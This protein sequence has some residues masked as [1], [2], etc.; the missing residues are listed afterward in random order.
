MTIT[1]LI[2][3]SAVES[4]KTRT[5]IVMHHERTVGITRLIGKRI[6]QYVL[7]N[8]EEKGPVTMQQVATFT[9]MDDEMFKWLCEES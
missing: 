4:F 6:Y 1:N 5:E 7:S 9:K 8:D 3:R 2:T